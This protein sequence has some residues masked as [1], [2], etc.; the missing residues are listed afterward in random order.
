MTSKAG[1]ISTAARRFLLGNDG[2]HNMR[3]P[4]RIVKDGLAR[5]LGAAAETQRLAGIRIDV[6]VRKI[7]A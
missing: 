1:S 7:A 3:R 5:D 6:I 2:Q 4:Y